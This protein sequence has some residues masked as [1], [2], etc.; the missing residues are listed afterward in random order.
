MEVETCPVSFDRIA[1]TLRFHQLAEGEQIQ[2]AEATI[3]NIELNHPGKAYAYRV[4]ADDALVVLATDG[5][6][7]NLDH[8][9]TKKY[10][11]FFSNVDALIFDAMFSVRESFIKEDWG[12]SSALIGADFAKDANVKS[13]FLFHHDPTTTDAEIMKVLHETKEYLGPNR[14]YPEVFAA[15][16]GVEIEVDNT[17]RAADF[18]MDNYVEHG[19]V[20]ITLS[21]KFGSQVT[22]QFRNLLAD[23]LRI[24]QADKVILKMENLRELTMAGIRALVDTRRSVISLALVG[25]PENVYRVLELAGTTDFFAIYKDDEAALAALNSNRK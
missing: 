8:A 23:S 15:Q 19:V 17:S 2:I 14:Q 16:E 11:K 5:E 6:Y 9:S 3:T 7:T 13:L 22:E 10:R 25:M 21:G 24:H 20:F 1:D 12:H 4:E 18:H